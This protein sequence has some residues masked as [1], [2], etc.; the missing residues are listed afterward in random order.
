MFLELLGTL[1]RLQLLSLVWGAI[2]ALPKRGHRRTNFYNRDGTTTPQINQ[3]SGLV[4][5]AAS[6][7]SVICLI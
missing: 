2:A 4:A 7:S 5:S 3:V 6:F 1:Q